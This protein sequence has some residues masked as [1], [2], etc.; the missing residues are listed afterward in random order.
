MLLN[1]QIMGLGKD[2]PLNSLGDMVPRVGSPMQVGCPVPR[3][4][5]DL[6]NKVYLSV[7]HVN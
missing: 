6:S 1:N 4:D 5:S 7:L 2:G 3:G